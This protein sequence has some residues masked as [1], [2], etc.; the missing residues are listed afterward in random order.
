MRRWWNGRHACFRRMCPF[1]RE[2]SN[3]FLRILERW[4]SSVRHRTRNP[5]S[6]F[7]FT[8]GFKSRPFLLEQTRHELRSSCLFC[9]FIPASRRPSARRAKS[10]KPRAS[11]RTEGCRPA[12]WIP[13]SSLAF[14]FFGLAKAAGQVVP[15]CFAAVDKASLAD[16]EEEIFI[17][18]S[19]CWF[20]ATDHLQNGRVDIWCWHKDGARYNKGY[21][22]SHIVLDC[23]G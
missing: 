5:A 21:L 19:Y 13:A 23:N 6:G 14:D 22:S 4:P 10:S 11:P 17:L 9:Y 15:K 8:R 1:G 2:G 12:A 7:I 16:R 3:P 18:D 20:F